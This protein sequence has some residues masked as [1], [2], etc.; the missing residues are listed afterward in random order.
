[1]SCELNWIVN[2]QANAAYA[3]AAL[4][5][6]GQP[7]DVSQTAALDQLVNNL[8]QQASC[9]DT[10][11]IDL[12]NHVAPLCQGPVGAREVVENA[13]R[14][15][16][17]SDF[18]AAMVDQCSDAV[19]E[20]FEN[21][22]KR[23]PDVEHELKLR[24]PVFEQNWAARGP[25]LLSSIGRFTDEDLIASRATVFLVDPLLGGGGTAYLAYNAVAI[26]AVL[27]NPHDD[28]PE[29]AR[30]AWLLAQLRMDAPIHGETVHGGRLPH[31]AALAI[32]PPTLQAAEVVELCRF[33]P[34]TVQR[35]IE[36]W[37]IDV[38]DPMSTADMV[39]QWWDIYTR[40]R[41]RWSV[42][43]AALDKML[44]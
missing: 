38:A 8:R 3:A 28:L 29:I 17:A 30:L 18:A 7:A 32:L 1:V 34:E 19:Q 13:L 40:G 21:W 15:L 31:V 9:K 26:E 2:P 20:L 24:R 39:C 27:A 43:L 11:L 12:L 37:N 4:L 22:H 6:G 33:S 42:A 36:V 10:A 14:K 44:E 25:G 41:P 35:A 16:V 5:G 23:F